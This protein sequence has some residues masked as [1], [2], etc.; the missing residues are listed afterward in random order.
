MNSKPK[1]KKN[2]LIF[3]VPSFIPADSTLG[4]LGCKYITSV[5][6]ASL[7][8]II[9]EN[10]LHYEQI[11]VVVPTS[12]NPNYFLEKLNATNVNIINLCDISQILNIN[13]FSYV[14]VSKHTL[15]PEI[16]EALDTQ[17]KDIAYSESIKELLEL[18]DLKLIDIEAKITA[19]PLTATA[20]FDEAKILI[21]L[22]AEIPFISSLG[23][24]LSSRILEKQS[25]EILLGANVLLDEVLNWGIEPSSGWIKK[26]KLQNSYDCIC[27][28]FLYTFFNFEKGSSPSIYYTPRKIKLADIGDNFSIQ[29]KV[30]EKW[31]NFPTAENPVK[32]VTSTL[33]D[34]PDIYGFKIRQESSILK[35]HSSMYI[36]AGLGGF[37][38]ESTNGL[39]W[40]Y[41]F[42][43]ISENML[44]SD[45]A[46]KIEIHFPVSREGL[47][48]RTLGSMGKVS[49]QLFRPS[50]Q[51]LQNLTEQEGSNNLFGIRIIDG[52]SHFIGDFRCTIPLKAIEVI[53]ENLEIQT[54]LT[55]YCSIK[56]QNSLK[57]ENLISLH[58]SIY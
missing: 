33:R 37:E 6:E 17:P 40:D 12:G 22:L 10:K 47:S 26:I 4:S 57:N 13:S 15:N 19:L 27:N 53:C 8:S 31:Q 44:Q 49:D 25:I 42:E 46:I 52:L 1:E 34:S 29:F 14:L 39:T 32:L 24:T 51:G 41:W 54:K 50:E 9:D 36:K 56:D 16:N 11:I 30:N 38:K 18:A 58:L 43:E 2:L 28:P 21:N 3:L 20:K 48:F 5:Q 23:D 35:K 7:L 55:I 45:L